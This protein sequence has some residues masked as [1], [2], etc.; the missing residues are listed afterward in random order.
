M[1]SPTRITGPPPITAPGS[2]RL[3]LERDHQSRRRQQALAGDQRRPHQTH[4]FAA[5]EDAGDVRR[6][7]RPGAAHQRAQDRGAARQVV[8]GRQV[9]EAIR[10]AERPDVEDAE[11]PRRHGPAGLEQQLQLPVRPLPVAGDP[12]RRLLRAALAVDEAHRDGTVEGVARHAAQQPPEER[13]RL[14]HVEPGVVGVGAER[15]RPAPGGAG[16]ARC[17]TSRLP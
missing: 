12:P 1:A 10:L 14:H 16:A 11:A 5:G 4:L 15:D 3:G 7:A 6:Q 8:G 9:Q 13:L 17:Q 2:S